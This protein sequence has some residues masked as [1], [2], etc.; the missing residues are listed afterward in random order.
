MLYMLPKFHSYFTGLQLCYQCRDNNS[1]TANHS[2]KRA[3][4]YEPT[5]R[6]LKITRGLSANCA[7][8]ILYHFA[9]LESI[10]YCKTIDMI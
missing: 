2:N 10:N 1:S 9:Y 8:T 3:V 4:K 7:G 6:P 5:L